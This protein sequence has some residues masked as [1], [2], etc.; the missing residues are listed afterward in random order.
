MSAW[1]EI[2]AADVVE[3]GDRIMDPY[4]EELKIISTNGFMVVFDDG[5]GWMTLCGSR[6]G[7]T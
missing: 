2:N 3:D 6:R 7:R 5:D 4:G 1:R